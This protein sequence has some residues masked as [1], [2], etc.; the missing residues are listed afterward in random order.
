MNHKFRII[1]GTPKSVEIEL[2]DLKLNNK[3]ITVL[4]MSSTVESTTVLIEV[5]NKKTPTHQSGF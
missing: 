4:G 5:L 1:T 2:N 3:S